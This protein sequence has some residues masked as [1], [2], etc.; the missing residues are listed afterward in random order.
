[1]NS[2][3]ILSGSLLI[4]AAIACCGLTKPSPQAADGT[5]APS[6]AEIEAVWPEQARRSAAPGRAAMMCNITLQ[7][8]LD[9]C[10]TIF[11][12]PADAGFG[13]ALQSLAPLY[14]L[15]DSQQ[16]GSN[17]ALSVDWFSY[18]QYATWAALPDGADII[19][20]IPARAL[21]A[22]VEGHVRM[23]CVVSESGRLSRCHPLSESPGGFGFAD[24]AVTMAPKFSLHPATLGGRPVVSTVTI[25][26]SLKPPR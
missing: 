7:R 16:P 1:M 13:A 12:E 8:T 19:K 11:E 25:P 26:I 4:A 10:R 9:A 15:S 5:K 17:V 20:A 18:D 21:T 14:R 23:N 6:A 24:A 3:S 22:G 2:I